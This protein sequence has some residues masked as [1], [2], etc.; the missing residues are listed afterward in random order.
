MSKASRKRAAQKA[1]KTRAAN[2]RRART[3]ERQR[4]KANAAEL[5][6][7]ERLLGEEFETL[8]EA[9]KALREETTVPPPSKTE[10]D[11]ADDY[12]RLYDQWDATDYDFEDA[13]EIDAGVDY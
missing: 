11:S 2:Q 6:K 9:R 5:A 10:V 7:I 3:A 1:A 13:G 12:D 8:A 4:E